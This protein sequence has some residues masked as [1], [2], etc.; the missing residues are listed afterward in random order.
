[1][2]TLPELV[3][4]ETDLNHLQ[5]RTFRV[6]DVAGREVAVVAEDAG[7]RK[8]ITKMGRWPVQVVLTQDQLDELRAAVGARVIVSFEDGS[9]QF[10]ATAVD[11]E[12]L[13]D[14]PDTTFDN[15]WWAAGTEAERS[16][17]LDQMLYG[18]RL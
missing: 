14:E 4:T 6:I 11:D 15:R 3:L 1:M 5:G 17:L 16:A 13:D 10:H 7:I 2:P 8:T 9:M 18:G 12:P